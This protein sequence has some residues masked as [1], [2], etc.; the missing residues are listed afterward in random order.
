MVKLLVL[1]DLNITLVDDGHIICKAFNKAITLYGNG[2][3]I[4]LADY[5]KAITESGGSIWSLW[6]S[7]GVFKGQEPTEEEKNKLR[8]CWNAEYLANIDNLQLAPGAKEALEELYRMKIPM[9]IVTGQDPCLIKPVFNKFNLWKYFQKTSLPLQETRTRIV[10]IFGQKPPADKSSA[11]Q[12]MMLRENALT[13][14]YVCDTPADVLQAHKAGA[15]AVVYLNY[16]PPYVFRN[17][18]PDY[19][20]FHFS[21]LPPL[22]KELIS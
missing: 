3:E 15:K 4:K 13:C 21:Q 10:S 22:V 1:F 20:I 6:K 2:E 19:V 17:A 16:Q 8:A 14:L 12:R 5:Y 7:K 18:I 11:I 9:G